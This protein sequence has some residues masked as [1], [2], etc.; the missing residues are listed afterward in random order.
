MTLTT[1]MRTSKA[2]EG[3]FS[4][5]AHYITEEFEMHSGHLQCHHLP[6]IH[7]HA[8]I[9]EAIN[10]SLADWYIQLDNDVVA[11]VTD[12]ESNIKKSNKR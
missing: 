2:G 3:Y 12:N 4:L 7:D 10:D 11:F 6:G 1:D 5:T 8:H 9:S